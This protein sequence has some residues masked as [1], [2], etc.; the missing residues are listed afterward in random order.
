[1]RILSATDVRDALPMTHAIAAMRQAFAA[2]TAGRA[3]VPERIHLDIPQHQGV[4]LIMPSFVRLDD[5]EA[6][7]TKIVS[8]FAGNPGRGLARIQAAVIVL[9]P[10][11]G[12]PA[13]VLEG[14][15]LTAIRTGAASGLATDLLA[16]EDCRTVAVFGAGVQAR[17]QLEAVCAVR[18]IESAWIVDPI[19]G[20]V[21]EFIQQ[22]AGR[23]GLP[24]HIR[25]AADAREALVE[26]DIVNLAT[27]AHTPPFADAD[28]RPGTHIN[29]IGSYQPHVQEVPPETVV[30]ALVVVDS[31]QAALAETGD[32]IRPIEQGLITADH[33]HAELGELAL[34]WKPGRQNAEQITLFKSV[35]VA[36]QDAVAARVAL[37]RA[38]EL[39][40]GT[41]VP[42]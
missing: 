5:G 42:W 19:P 12:R 33:I 22:T 10:D 17:T 18:D 28:L 38:E 16:R 40:L 3:D 1:M 24:A 29:A 15:T 7:A 6:L 39:G 37:A 25:R 27:T 31:R 21:D 23:V 8:L 13:A 32:L 4:S 9:E 14:A 20:R 36:V 2:L 30:R 11:T 26:A 35:G 34:G 41:E